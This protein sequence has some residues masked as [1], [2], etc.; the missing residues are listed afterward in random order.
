MSMEQA[1]LEL[2]AALRDQAAAQREANEVNRATAAGYE[3]AVTAYAMANAPVEVAGGVQH[4]VEVR[5]QA[6][7]LSVQQ[8]AEHFNVPADVLHAAVAEKSAGPV[9]PDADLEQ[10]VQKVEAGAGKVEE[11]PGAA[12]LD[13]NKDV[14][15]VLLSLIKA[16]GKPVLV[17]MLGRYGVEKADALSADALPKVLAEVQALLAA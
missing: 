7:G 16:K 15:P 14:K 9:K 4:S 17:E 6:E 12:P 3:R 10:A 13:Y 11:A 2:A 1:I 5:E 8:V